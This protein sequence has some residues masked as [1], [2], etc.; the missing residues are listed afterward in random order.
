M[1]IIRCIYNSLFYSIYS[2][3]KFVSTSDENAAIKSTVIMTALSFFTFLICIDGISYIFELPYIQ[4][5]D[6]SWVRSILIG[7][8]MIALY[9]FN[10]LLFLGWDQF[11]KLDVK[12]QDEKLLQKIVRISFTILYIFAVVYL[13]SILLKHIKS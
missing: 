7:L 2:V 13:S 11:I 6:G 1:N 8:S 5:W 10:Y 9:V 4:I 12:Y 3:L